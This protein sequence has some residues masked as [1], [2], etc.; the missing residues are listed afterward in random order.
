MHSK[1]SAVA[2]DLAGWIEE[3]AVRLLEGDRLLLRLAPRVGKS[4]LVRLLGATLG[5]T[6][7]IVDGADFTEE[8]QAGQRARLQSALEA[9]LE[10]HGSA[11]LLFDGFDRAL[12]RTQGPRLQAWLTKQLID[13]NHARDLGA[14]FT[15]RCSTA[16]HRDGAGS[17]LMSRVAPILPPTRSAPNPGAELERS[18]FGDA[19]VI[20]DR[21]ERVGELTPELL[22]DQFEVDPTFIADVRAAAGALIARGTVDPIHDSY[23]ARCASYG[24]LHIGGKTRFLERLEPLLLGSQEPNPAWPEQTA[25]SIERFVDLIAGA[26]QVLWSDRYMFRDI[27]PLRSFVQAVVSRSDTEIHLLGG[28]EVNDRVVSRAEMAR[29]TSLAKVSARWMTSS[30]FRNLHERHLV[31][32]TGGWVIPQVHVIVG[33]QRPGSAVAAPT[34][35][36]GVDYWTIWK[37]SIDPSH[38]TAP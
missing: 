14:L 28:A 37:R 34:S 9:T 33:R 36:F 27:E 38:L 3:V 10:E 19:A 21:V 26:D 32:G 30:D 1:D 20:A 35:G 2:E 24:L 12:I 31:T 15:A 5:P 8:D 11:Q 17:P 25:T 18:W 4:Y 16:T 13:G 22:V 6:A 23:A 29:L 7:V